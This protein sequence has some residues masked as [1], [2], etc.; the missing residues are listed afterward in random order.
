MLALTPS[1]FSA[2]A[3]AWIAVIPTI[4]SALAVAAAV[5][6]PKLSAMKAQFDA[7][8]T[9]HNNLHQQVAAQGQSI[10]AVSLAT[11]APGTQ[12]L[13][14]ATLEQ[15]TAALQENTAATQ[16][17]TAAQVAADNQQTQSALPASAD[18]QSGNNL[19]ADFAA[20]KAMEG[21]LLPAATQ[22]GQ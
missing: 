8:A 9:A 22:P 18:T 15:T 20:G 7:L 16:A 13:L 6:L 17:D 1:D 10:A 12:T 21:E 5:V 4:V 14:P 11:P 19:A 3:I 2:A